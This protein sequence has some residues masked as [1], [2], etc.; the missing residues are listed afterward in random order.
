MTR[1]L[2][3]EQMVYRQVKEA[4]LQKAVEDM[5]TQFGWKWFHAPDNKPSRST[6]R[7]QRVVPGF[8][9]I[10]AL[11]G[12]RIVIIENKRETESPREDQEEWLEAWR[13][14]GK[15]EVFVIRPST[16]RSLADVLKPDWMKT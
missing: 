2:T 16:M 5:L 1:K 11:R 13:R 6:G 14:T 15:A 7:V 12:T 9:D 4:A 10:V 3:A 8:P